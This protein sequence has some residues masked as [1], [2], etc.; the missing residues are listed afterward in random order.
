MYQFTTE[1]LSVRPWR[2]VLKDGPGRRQLEAALLALLSPHVLRHLPSPLQLDDGNGGISAWV[3]ARSEESDVL[4]VADKDTGALVGL[5]ILA[6]D[7]NHGQTPMLHLG[8]LLGEKAWGRGLGSELVAGLVAAASCDGPLILVG[9]VSKDNP[10]SARVLA[11]AGFAVAPERATPD[12]D[13]Y[14]RMID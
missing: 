13:M 6:S 12:S 7:A 1:R 10:A 14:V 5:L 2:P 4:L 9:G 8:Y 3:E 11:K